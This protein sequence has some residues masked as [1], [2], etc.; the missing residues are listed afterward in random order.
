[1][2]AFTCFVFLTAMTITVT[3]SDH[4]LR[5]HKGQYLTSSATCLPCPRGTFMPYKLHTSNQC[6]SCLDSRSDISGYK[7]TKCGS[8]REKVHTPRS[9]RSDVADRG[10]VLYSVIEPPSI[11]N[12]TCRR[13]HYLDVTQHTCSRCPTCTFIDQDRHTQA[14]CDHCSL[15]Q[16]DNRLA[17]CPKLCDEEAPGALPTWARF[18]VGAMV[19]VA[20]PF[21]FIMTPLLLNK[22][23]NK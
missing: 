20:A 11:T 4:R 3:R 13:N 16:P 15:R 10:E 8:V 12:L 19:M 5:C 17:Y 23:V 18:I 1:M 7:K 6:I 9:R 22:F 2:L 14:A 21:M